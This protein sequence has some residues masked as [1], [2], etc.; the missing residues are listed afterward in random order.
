[1][2]KH[3]EREATQRTRQFVSA[4]TQNEQLRA[5]VS[6]I[7]RLCLL[8]SGY[9]L[10]CL[11]YSAGFSLEERHDCDV[12]E[13]TEEECRITLRSAVGLSLSLYRDDSSYAMLPDRLTVSGIV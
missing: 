5:I 13:W 4:G 6:V 8:Q 7:V 10:V 3:V 9:L 11:S 2:L 1:V 12:I